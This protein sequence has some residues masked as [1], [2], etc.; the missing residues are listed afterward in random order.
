MKIP[1]IFL[2]KNNL[3]DKVKDL[4][5]SLSEKV[6]T[7]EEFKRRNMKV[8]YCNT[9]KEETSQL[10]ADKKK[11]ELEDRAIKKILKDTYKGLIEWKQDPEDTERYTA[12]ATVLNAN[13]EKI[14][15]PILF[16]TIEDN[17]WEKKRGVLQFGDEDGPARYT[18]R[19]EVKKLADYFKIDID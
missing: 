7:V 12:H 5:K 10:Y 11:R 15:I 4:S 16:H 19:L 8:F 3:D 18:C 13:D 17:Y 9:D 14:T 6:L 1:N 2:P